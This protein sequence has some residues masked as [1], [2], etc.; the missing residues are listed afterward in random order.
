MR[1]PA[2]PTVG[3]F[4]AENPSRTSR[5]LSPGTWD[6]LVA[7]RVSKEHVGCLEL[8]LT[9]I[10]TSVPTIFPPPAHRR[11]RA[12]QRTAACRG[13]RTQLLYWAVQYQV[14][15][16][17]LDPWSSTVETWRR[18]PLFGSTDECAGNMQWKLRQQ[19]AKV[20]DLPDI[21]RQEF[22]TTD[23][24]PQLSRHVADRDIK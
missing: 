10:S 5:L 11:K 18:C 8:L 13:S 23:K 16:L 22:E 19:A 2:P 24:P 6:H 20:A 15:S 21:R 1:A 12:S 3:D 9:M 4:A 7:W 17:S 14:D